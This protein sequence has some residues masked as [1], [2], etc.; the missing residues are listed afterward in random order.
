VNNSPPVTT[1]SGAIRKRLSEIDQRMYE[2][3]R[4]VDIVAQL[5]RDGIKVSLKDFRQLLYRAR[6]AK[7]KLEEKH[8][9]SSPTANLFSKEFKQDQE[10]ISK[11]TRKTQPPVNQKNL[12][13]QKPVE[14]KKAGKMS[15]QDIDDLL[16]NPL[17][18]DNM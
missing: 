1:I 5:N 17:D 11:K 13:E 2:G 12:V 14:E 18:L 9:D 8:K 4:Q 15:V 6:K 10:Q 3:E 7:Q 16:K